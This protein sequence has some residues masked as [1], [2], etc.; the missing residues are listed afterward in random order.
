MPWFGADSLANGGFG[1][2][3]LTTSDRTSTTRQPEVRSRFWETFRYRRAVRFRSPITACCH[4][5][6]I[7]PARDAV[8]SGAD[9]HCA[10]VMLGQ[11]FQPPTQTATLTTGA[12]AGAGVLAV[13][14]SSLI[15][16]GNLSLLNTSTATLD[17]TKA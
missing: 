1:A 2:L 9:S 8:E 14:A 11:P 7:P 12:T 10:Y 5:R 16:V 6:L 3:T 13:H 15:D 17:A 4:W